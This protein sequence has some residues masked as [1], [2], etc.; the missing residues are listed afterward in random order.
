MHRRQGE[1]KINAR[2]VLEGVQGTPLA[3]TCTAHQLSPSQDAQG[4]DPLLA[5]AAPAVEA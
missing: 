3:D 4:R 2:R 5:P 1:A